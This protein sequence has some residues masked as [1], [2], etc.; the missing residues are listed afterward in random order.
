MF[1]QLLARF[2][3]AVMEL[4]CAPIVPAINHHGYLATI[5]HTSDHN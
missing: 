4:G 1:W 2:L 5:G 3:Q